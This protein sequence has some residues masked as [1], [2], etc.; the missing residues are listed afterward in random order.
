[1]SPARDFRAAGR[2]GG[3]GRAPGL[4]RGAVGIRAVGADVTSVGV[5]AVTTRGA[6][7]ARAVAPRAG[8]ATG[9]SGQTAVA[10]SS[11]VG[12]RGSGS[13]ERARAIALERKLGTSARRVW[14]SGRSSQSCL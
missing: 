7:G 5:S 13:L 9:C 11:M 10:N 1:M 3:A 8:A 14:R 4:G 2:E 6:L 12:K